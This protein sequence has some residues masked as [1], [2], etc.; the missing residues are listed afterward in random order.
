[1]P[2]NTITY[3]LP[4]SR[5]TNIGWQTFYATNS[6]LFLSLQQP[7]MYN[8]NIP[9]ISV[10]RY[11]LVLMLMLASLQ[12]MA[13]HYRAGEI[14]YEAITPKRFKITAISY[15]DPNSQADPGTIEIVLYFGDG[16]HATIPRTGRSTLSAKVV[17]NVYET[18]H[19]YRSEGKYIISFF[20]QNRVNGIIN[21]NGGS[22]SQI[23][24]YVETQITINSILG[25]NRSPILTKPPIDNGCLL[26]PYYHNPSAYDPDGDSLVFTIIPPKHAEGVDAPAYK[27][28]DADNAFRIGINDGQLYWDSPKKNGIYNIAILIREYRKGFLMGYTIRDMQIEIEGCV[29]NPPLVQD[30]A[31]GCVVVGD[32]ISRMITAND[33]DPNGPM[34]RL[35]GYGGAF[36]TQRRATINPDPAMNISTVSTQFTWAPSCNHIRYRSWQVIFEARDDASSGSAVSQNSFNVQVIAPPVINLT[37][38]QVNKGFRLDWNRDTC[39]MAGEYKIYRRVDSSHWNP[40]NC[41][42]GIPASTGFE[43]IGS[44]LTLNNPNSTTFYDDNK[45]AGLSPLVNYCYRIVTVYPPRAASGQIIYSEPAESIASEEICDNIVLSEPS[46]TKVSVISTSVTTGKVEINYIKPDTLDTLSY[47][48]PYRFIVRRASSGNS[49]FVNISDVSFNDFAPINTQTLID[50]LVNTSQ[51]LTYEVELFA[52]LNGTSTSVGKSTVATSVFNTIYCTDRTNILSWNINVP[53]HN[54]TFVVYRKNSINTFDSIGYTTNLSYTDTGLVNNVEY[55]Y[56][57]KSLGKFRTRTQDTSTINFSQEIC[58]TPID[59]VKPCPPPLVVVSPCD[60]IGQFENKLYWTPNKVCANDVV[61]YRVYYKQLKTNN[62]ILIKELSGNDTS[63]IDDRQLLKDAITGCYFI[64]GVDSAGNESLP[65]NEVCIEN[66]PQYELPNVFTPNADGFNDLFR[67][68]PYRFV[69]SIDMVIY[70]RWGIP[71]F[72]TTN[73]DVLW[74]G[75]DQESKMEL[76]DGVYYYTCIVNEVYLEGIRQRK[77]NGT[78]Q[79]I[80]NRN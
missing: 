11:C 29:N 20:D 3:H 68:F 58:G 51:Q 59:T 35:F 15:S 39:N 22:T 1:L 65:L 54:D 23:Q 71:V 28:P 25:P 16:T 10:V 45:G 63:Y 30:I 56:V 5:V 26:K 18:V 21:I 75:K 34:V 2:P 17:K 77:L 48:P 61:L 76:P 53:W 33:P 37:T 69:S 55:C 66:C 44:V 42:V 57:V 4:S 70:N 19:E 27:D 38:T 40:G 32:S 49:T 9:F 12:S 80:R 41:Q 7:F 47:L 24:F 43:Q 14:L 6:F 74:D 67:P 46:L 31:D 78:V 73:R 79:I 8:K 64:A 50:S 52:Q 60:E 72:T 13:T 36:A 62:Y